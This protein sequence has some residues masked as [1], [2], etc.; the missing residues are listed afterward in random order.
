MD[1]LHLLLQKK[2]LNIPGLAIKGQWGF[3]N[4]DGDIVLK[5]QYDEAFPFS[6]GRAFVRIR[7]VNVYGGGYLKMID[8]KGTGNIFF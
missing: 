6:Q 7:D 5:E 8:K 4:L 2:I 3:I 1:L